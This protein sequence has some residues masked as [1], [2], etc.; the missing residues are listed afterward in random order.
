MDKTQ[1]LVL[2]QNQARELLYGELELDY[3]FFTDLR[4][5]SDKEG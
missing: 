2:K 5:N 1:V 4:K 3:Y